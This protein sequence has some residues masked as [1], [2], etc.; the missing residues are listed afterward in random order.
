MRMHSLLTLLTTVILINCNSSG[1]SI[2]AE[3]KDGK[4][5]ISSDHKELLTYHFETVYPPEGVDTVF[6]R[7]GF[8]H[9]LNT[10]SGKVLTRI[11]PEDHYH[12]YG[13]WNPWTHV[14]FEEDTL[15]FWN[16]Y[17]HE[18]T[19]RHAGFEYV[20]ETEEYVEFKVLHEHVVLKDGANKVALNEYQTIRVHKL[21][22]DYYNV[23][24]TFEYSP[25]KESPFKILEYR[26][27]GFGWRT[28]GFWDN[29]NSVVITSEGK[30]RK[31]SD[32]STAT[33]YIA[34]GD[35]EEGDFGGA[36]VMSNPE[37]FNHPEP[38]RVWPFD[39][40]GRGDMFVCF[41]TT[42][43]TDWVFEPGNTYTLQYRMKVF[44]G[45]QTAESAESAFQEYA[46]N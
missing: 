14:L 44:T 30:D 32:G 40:Y 18:G 31:T 27:A 38:L 42:K 6:K 36:V 35:L 34:Q 29:Q 45:E 24:L 16:L 33:W 43:N 9:P 41:C 12:H 39:Q 8:I 17:K 28:T 15:D 2:K 7:S 10:P 46:G 25:G 37:N 23:D 20:E 19:V 13:I 21:N 5:V 22:G 1:S 3:K 4:L 26:Y 11:Q